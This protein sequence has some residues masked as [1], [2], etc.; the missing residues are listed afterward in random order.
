MAFIHLYFANGDVQS[1]FNVGVNFIAAAAAVY[2]KE[3]LLYTIRIGMMSRKCRNGQLSA[4]CFRSV[5]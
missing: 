3:D 1:G 4:K 2:R 5:L